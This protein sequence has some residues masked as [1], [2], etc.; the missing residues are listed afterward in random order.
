MKKSFVLL[1]A[2]VAGLSVSAQKSKARVGISG[3]MTTSNIYGRV[4][5]FDTRGDVRLGYTA[6]MIVDAPIKGSKLTFQPGVH[7]VQKGM[8]TTKSDIYREAHA[9]RYA[10]L[11]LNLVMKH[12]KEGKARFYWGVGPQ[13]ALNLPSKVVQWDNGDKK[14]LRRISFGETALNDY[15][16]I[17]YGANGLMGVELKNGITMSINYTLGLRNI[18]P[19]G[20]RVNDDRLRNGCF[21][22][23]VGYFFKNTN[24]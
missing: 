20:K 2:V 6:G 14:E 4:G 16:G 11:L 10:D 9:M 24:K 13:V 15:Q 5:G 18:Y 22:V 12:G 21:A 8:Y 23:R 17:D 19:D 3:G 7:Y 1:L